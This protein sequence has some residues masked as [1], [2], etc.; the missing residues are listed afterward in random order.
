ML[1]SSK[2][3]FLYKNINFYEITIINVRV[4]V[5]VTE[6]TK[7]DWSKIKMVPIKRQRMERKAE[8]TGSVTSRLG[9]T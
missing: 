2:V 5:V 1:L 3:S 8:D 4:R 9:S 7:K 6:A